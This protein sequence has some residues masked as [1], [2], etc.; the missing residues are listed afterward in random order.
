M[1]DQDP[2]RVAV[3]MGGW[4]SE[5]A[6]S[7]VSA[8]FCAKAAR[9]A[10]WDAI[11]VEFDRDIQTR[12]KEI[13]PSRVYNALHGQ[14][15]EDGSVQ[16]M[17]NIMGIP[18]THSGVVASAVAMNKV[19]SR[20]LFRTGGIAVPTRLSLREDNGLL[21]PENYE[22]DYVI[23]PINEGS[24]FGVKIVKAGEPP[25]SHDQWEVG[26]QLFAEAFIPGKEL[27]VSVLDGTALGVTEI[28][29]DEAFY[30]FDAKYK[31]GGSR[32][33][34]PAEIP[35]EVETLALDWAEA[36]YQLLGCRGV[37][38]ADY[39]YDDKK[40]QLYMLEVNTQPGMTATSLVPEQALW[41]GISGEE[42]VNH[43]LEIAQCDD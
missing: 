28:T 42:L 6:V 11:E 13:N 16:G 1:R 19:I 17:L 32:H 3:I 41:R 27:T 43:L 14:I 12:L 30:D 7:R 8:A 34:L 24:S 38:R 36:A 21:M 4:T 20:Q 31:A 33:I 26:T 5:A 22:S 15:G 37:A 2:R 18:Y 35:K 39:R 29:T 25:A 10:G 23:K 40:N 9:G